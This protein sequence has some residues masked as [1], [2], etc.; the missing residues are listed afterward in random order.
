[1]VADDKDYKNK[2]FDCLRKQEDDE[3][4]WD[5]L[6]S[7]LRKAITRLSISAKGHDTRVT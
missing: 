1:M 2:Y 6:E 4:S 7:L 5:D 3:K